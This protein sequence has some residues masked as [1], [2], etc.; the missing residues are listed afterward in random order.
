MKLSKIDPGSA[1]ALNVIIEIPYGTHIKYEVDH[2]NGLLSV[3]RIMHSAMFYPANYGYVPNTLAKDGD[4]L[5][6]LVLNEYAIYPGALIKCRV[7]GVLMMEDESG[8]DEKVLAMP[9]A[10]IDPN[11]AHI[12]SMKDLS[13]H[14]LAMIKNFFE[15][16]KMLEP[17]KW[18]KVGEYE[19]ADKAAAILEDC[20]KAHKAQKSDA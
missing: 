10:K 12:K 7:I 13:D 5:D 4:P 20:I 16:Y 8:M 9:V 11:L 18:V 15:T 14:R 3:D 1:D 6:V 19:G 2:K 17:N